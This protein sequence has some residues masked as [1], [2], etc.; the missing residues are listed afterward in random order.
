ML[1]FIDGTHAFVQYEKELKFL[2]D[3]LNHM[4]GNVLEQF[5]RL[6][7]LLADGKDNQP[8]AKKDVK[9]IDQDINQMQRSLEQGV[10][11]I[12]SCYTPAEQEL[13]LILSIIKLASQLERMGDHCQNTVKHIW[14]SDSEMSEEIRVEFTKLVQAVGYILDQLESIIL[15]FD[16]NKA[17]ELLKADDQVDDLYKKL[18][19]QIVQSAGSE[20]T[21]KTISKELLAAKNLERLADHAIDVIYETY[22]IHHGTR[23]HFEAA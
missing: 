2:I 6:K 14:R 20:V 22:Y 7:E 19:I 12:I 8:D 10:H 11:R 5:A 4:R 23:L 15:N 1:R 3:G 21:E 18:T 17:V 13:R 9:H 16:E